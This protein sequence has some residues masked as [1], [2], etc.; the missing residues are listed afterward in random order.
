ME[1]LIGLLFFSHK[2]RFF[3]LPHDH[4]SLEA[5]FITPCECYSFL[6]ITFTDV[7][8]RDWGKKWKCRTSFVS[9][10]M[11]TRKCL[12]K[13][14]GSVSFL[15]LF[16]SCIYLC[17]ANTTP[18]LLQ[19]IEWVL[20]LHEN[21]SGTLFDRFFLPSFPSLLSSHLISFLH[22]SILPLCIII[23]LFHAF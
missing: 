19:S 5:Y 7:R 13:N 12:L 17:Y 2:M 11:R 23:A 16:L 20:S 3:A 22:F 8:N 1:L 9:G 10:N 6:L 14:I 15:F 21:Y 4:R 18:Y